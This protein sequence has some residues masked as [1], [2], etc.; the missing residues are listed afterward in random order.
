MQKW[1]I[2]GGLKNLPRLDENWSPK[3]G[4]KIGKLDSGSWHQKPKLQPSTTSFKAKTWLQN[5]NSGKSP[6]KR[7]FS[8]EVSV[9]LFAFFD[10]LFLP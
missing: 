3:S 9:L 6:K 7:Y 5:R 8:S 1:K 2:L 10:Y 4:P